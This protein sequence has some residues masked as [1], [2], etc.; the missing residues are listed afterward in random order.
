[1]GREEGTHIGCD[2]VTMIRRTTRRRI[3]AIAAGVGI[4]VFVPC[5]LVAASGRVGR[6]ERGIFRAVNGLPS[7]LSPA[8]RLFQFLG[9]L[10][11]GPVVAL[12]AVGVRRYRLALASVLITLLK[13]LAERF[14]WNVLGIRRDRP[15]ATVSGAIVR[16]GTPVSG[17]SFVSGHVM[18][19]TA[20]AWAIT[21]YLRGGWR[22]APWVA[23]IMVACARLYLGAHNPL[24]VLGGAGVGLAIGACVN[25]AVGVGAET[26]PEAQGS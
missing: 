10:A 13:L 18:L 23:V 4:L 12:V 19:A 11:I 5:A 9:V 15:G 20:L 6:V 26:R 22:L 2:P 24:D 1:V 21:P 17:V 14:I 7:I 3:D 25:L 8:M 16:G